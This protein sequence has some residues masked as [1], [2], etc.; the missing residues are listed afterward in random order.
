MPG[1]QGIDALR[2]ETLAWARGEAITPR[3][4][5]HQIAFNLI[6][7]IDRFGD[8]G[9]TG[10]ELKLVNETRKILEA[11]ELL[12]APTT[13]RVPVFTCHSVA[14]NAE[15]EEKITAGRAR[16]LFARFPGLRVWDEPAEQRYP[17]PVA[18]RG[19]GRLLRR[20]RARRPLAPARAELLGGRRPATQRGRDERGADRGARAPELSGAKWPWRGRRPCRSVGSTAAGA[21]RRTRQAHFGFA[22]L[23]TIVVLAYAGVPHVAR[24]VESVGG[25]NPGHYE[26]KDQAREAW[27]Q[28][29]D[30][31]D[32]VL[33]QIP[34]NTI[35]NVGLFL[36]VALVWMTSRTQ[37]GPTPPAAPLSEPR[38]YR[39]V[40][41]YDGTAFHGW[42]VQ[43][44][45][46]TVQGTLL[47]AAG[48]PLLGRRARGRAPVVPT[49][50][51]HALAPDRRADRR[52]RRS[53]PRPCRPPSTRTCP[54]RSAWWPPGRRRPGSTR[55]ARRS[56]SVTRI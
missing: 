7:A 50:G 33:S 31:P 22:V 25:Y 39:L 17:M 45:V 36:V 40:L 13:V 37:P 4:F 47:A 12:V 3:H 53:P 19:T 2:E 29:P 32:A 46:P 42:Q 35:I 30:D 26:P 43:P 34:W 41:S 56:A 6:P 24:F 11:P 14:V 9:Y 52:P 20:T 55:A 21:A 28:R 54:A 48:T 1:V 23:L 38:T 15:T 10:E 18:R 8:D 5:P 51:V 44:H 16:D 27:L 49:P